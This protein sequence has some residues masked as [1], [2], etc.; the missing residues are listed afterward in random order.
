MSVEFHQKFKPTSM[1]TAMQH[2]DPVAVGLL[3]V[4]AVVERLLLDVD[5][6]E[7]LV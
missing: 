2:D 7:R 4:V 1:G 6:M 3:D 5:A